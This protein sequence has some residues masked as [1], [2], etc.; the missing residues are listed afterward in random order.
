[1][2]YELHDKLV[3]A[4]STTALFDLAE[5][6]GIF[7][8]SGLEAYRKHQRENETKRLDPGTG[9]PLV[10]GL[11]AIN[12]LA[13]ER[14]VEVILMSR[15]DADSGYRITNSI[16]AWNLGIE[17]AAFT[18]GLPPTEY[19]ESFSCNLYL[20]TRRDEVLK[21]IQMRFPAALV[22]APPKNI[23]LSPNPVR[24]AFDG[25]A[26]IFSDEADRIYHASGLEAFYA[27]EAKLEKVPLEPGPLHG[28]LKGISRIQKRFPDDDKCP[29]RTALVTARAIPS[30]KRP[31]NTLRSW[32]IRL[33]ES[34]FLGGMEK[35]LVLER[36]K[37]HIFF[38][39]QK[40]NLEPAKGTVPVAEVPAEL[41]AGGIGR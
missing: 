13:G 27:S 8:E 36:L 32:D 4:I 21:A 11:L 22:Y 10:K 41:Q 28:F 26:V 25:D 17:R 24:I 37:P 38:D 2:A 29:I 5:A 9:F 18:D 16:E 34:F 30:H 31:L 23:D 14:L 39:D 40:A 12:E 33:D 20:T 19:L 7:R 35:R 15:N 3:V 6:D 1:V